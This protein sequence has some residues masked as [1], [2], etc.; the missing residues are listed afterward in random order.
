M[1][2]RMSVSTSGE[3]NEPAAPAE[4]GAAAEGL[5][6][7]PA[8]PRVDGK[9]GCLLTFLVGAATMALALVLLWR[10]AATQL[11]ATTELAQIVSVAEQAE[12]TPALVAAGCERA[13]VFPI[14]SLQHI[15]QRLENA[16]AKKENREPK[17]VRI[18]AYRS[19]VVCASSK[20]DGPSCKDVALAFRGGVKNAAVPFVT[21][22]ESHGG[23]TCIEAFDGDPDRMKAVTDVS[24]P[25]I[26]PAEP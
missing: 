10:K 5:P 19:A 26:F 17:D 23:P 8:G 15:V 18:G 22:V 6:E 7:A 24:V 11:D 20:K 21:V 14:D 25:A 2:S 13:A 4:D 9:L 12:G 1:S 3:G 16:R